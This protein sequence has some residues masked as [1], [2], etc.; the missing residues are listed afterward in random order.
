MLRKGADPKLLPAG[1][2]SVMCFAILHH[3]LILID[4]LIKA[5]VNLNLLVEE[6]QNTDLAFLGESSKSL[7]SPVITPIQLAV[8]LGDAEI[9]NRLIKG[10]AMLDKYIEPEVLQSMGQPLESWG[11]LTPLQISAWRCQEKITKILLDAGAAVDVRHSTTPTALQ[12][13]CRLPRRGQKKTELIEVLLTGGADINAPPGKDGEL[14]TM[15]AAAESGDHDLFKILLR[16]A[17]ADVK[18]SN[19]RTAFQ[20]AVSG[21][22]VKR[23]KLLIGA[24][25]D[26]NAPGTR[27]TALQAAVDNRDTEL[28]KLLVR[29]GAN[30]NTTSTGYSALQLAI[31]SNNVEL[32]KLFVQQG[33]DIDASAL[34]E[35]ALQTAANVGNLELVKYLIDN[36]ADI[37]AKAFNYRATALQYASMNGSIDMVKLLVDNGASVNTEPAPGYA[38]TALQLAVKQNR[39]QEAIYLIENGAS[40]E[41]LSS[42]PEKTTLLQLAAKQGN[43]RIVVCMVDNGATADEAPPTERGATALQFATINGNIKMAVFLIENG[44]R[45]TAKGAEID[46]RTALE[47]AA[48]HGRLDMVHLLLDNDEEPDTIEER[49]C[50]AAEFAET[51]HHDVIAR[52][53]RNYKRP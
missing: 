42:S 17:G 15:E 22:R 33:A 14:T 13:A 1:G 47:G 26:V 8:F 49:C 24:G 4:M 5:G 34:G 23:A 41:V 51:K 35:T 18:A 39:T 32:A 31:A 52:I 44:A 30:V 36:G 37:N 16:K 10:G 3:D 2:F 19:G 38:A 27:M 53:L 43:H 25:A 40:L 48:E 20:V 7:N 28:A 46:G 12:L 9:V 45:V 21:Y 29:A 11:L 6:L 50:N